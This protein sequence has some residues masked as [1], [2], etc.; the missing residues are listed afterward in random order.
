MLRYVLGMLALVFQY[1][2]FSFQH[3]IFF[4]VCFYFFLVSSMDSVSLPSLS[5]DFP[6]N[7]MQRWEW[8]RPIRRDVEY[9]R[10]VKRRSTHG[11][12]VCVM[13]P[14]SPCALC[15]LTVS[16]LRLLV[17]D[18]IKSILS[19]YIIKG[20]PRNYFEKFRRKIGN[21][22]RLSSKKSMKRYPRP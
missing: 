2:F 14:R 9:R 15:T 3:G 12:G 11:C 5:D 17:F 13:Y 21:Y 16:S 7:L 22:R 10:I 8:R 6:P 18:K 1:G 4:Q 19:N 20:K